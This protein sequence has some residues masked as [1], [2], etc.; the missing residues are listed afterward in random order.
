MAD[1]IHV[2]EATPNDVGILMSLMKEF[3]AEANFELDVQSASQSFMSLFRDPTYGCVWIVSIGEKPIGH[4]VLTV[5]FTM[6]HGGISGYVDD[7]FVVKEFRRHGAAH[8]MT[9]ELEKECRKRNCKAL[10]VEVGRDNTAGLRTYEKLGMRL[11]DD[12][13]ILYRKPL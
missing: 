8:A 7:L 9:M 12:G 5:R 6:E 4:A 3:Y 13:R 11:I 10:I 2:R 1:D